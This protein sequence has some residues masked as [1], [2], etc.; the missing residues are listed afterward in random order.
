MRAGSNTPSDA[1]CVSSKLRGFLI[2]TANWWNPEPAIAVAYLTRLFE[3]PEPALR[4][5]SDNQIAQ[6]LT[7]LVR[8][9]ARGDN[10]W[11]HS[12]DVPIADRVRCVE[13]VASLFK[14][15]FVARCTPHL[16]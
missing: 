13:A 4:W 1:R 8:T 16:S 3:R 11:L 9:S 2:M 14:Q 10:G 5:Y 15:L 7:Y 6:G 12:T